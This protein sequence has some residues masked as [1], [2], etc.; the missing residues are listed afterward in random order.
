MYCIPQL[1]VAELQEPEEEQMYTCYISQLGVSWLQQYSNTMYI[2][3]VTA[4]RYKSLKR[5]ASNKLLFH[6]QST[7]CS[8][9]NRCEENAERYMPQ[10]P[11][12]K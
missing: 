8:V 2:P 12:D 5:D 7:R 6:Y 11:E 9:C 3:H 1:G 4:A 10:E